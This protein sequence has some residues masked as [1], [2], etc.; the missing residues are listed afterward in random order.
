MIITDTK[1]TPEFLAKMINY[2]QD[3]T[4]SSKQGKKVFEILMNEGKDPEVIIEENS[5]KQISS[6]EEL[7]SN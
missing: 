4:I 6:P 7:Y 1:I 5:M 3:G 2:I